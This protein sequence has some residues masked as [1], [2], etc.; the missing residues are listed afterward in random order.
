M[1]RVTLTE[2]QRLELNR[3]AHQPGVAPSTRDRLEMVRL[4]DAG[5]SIPRIARHLHQHEQTVRAWVK[6]FLTGNFDALTNQPRGGSVSKLTPSILEAV[7][8]ELDKAERTWNAQQLADWIAERFGVRVQPGQVRRK[9]GR[10]H[11]SYKRTSRSLRHKQSA[12]DVA[13]KAE[14]LALLEKR[15]TPAR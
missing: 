4:S 14:A 1:Y 2:E 8:Q 15:G 3:R 12:P 10:A 6:A 7:G 9:L 13:V 5:W 11:L